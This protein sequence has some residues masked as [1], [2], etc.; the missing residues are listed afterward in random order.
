MS[1]TE[2]S[3]SA[4]SGGSYMMV[5]DNGNKNASGSQQA[6]SLDFSVKFV[7]TGAHYV[8]V[9]TIATNGSDDS[10]VPAY[11]NA[12]ITQMGV[13]QSAT[14]KWTKSSATFSAEI[15]IQSFKIFMREDGLK[16]D[17]IQLTDDANYTPSGGTPPPPPTAPDAPSGLAAS[18]TSS[19]QISLSWSDNASDE[20]GFRVER[21]TGGA[22]S[23]IAT[24][25]ANATS[26]SDT[27]LAAATAYS[28]RVRA[29]NSSGDSAYSG[30]AS[31]TTQA[32][33]GGGG[34]STYEAED[35]ASQSGTSL[36]SQGG[37]SGG[38]LVDYGG[39]GSYMQWDDISE[40]AGSATLTFTYYNGSSSNRQ[41]E[42]IV[43]G[44]NVGNVAFAP[45]GNW[46]TS[47]TAS[48]VATLA[49]GNNTVRVRANTGSGGPNLDYVE[50]SGGGAPPPTAPDAPSG[51]AASASSSSQIGLS[52]SDNASDET[53]FRVERSTGGAFSQVA[54]LGANATSYSDTGLAASTAYTYRV[55]AYNSS[56]DSAYSGTASATTQ[57][58][59]GGGGGS[60]DFYQ[61]ASSNGIVSM[62]AENA[63][64]SV[65]SSGGDTWQSASDGSASGATYMVVPDNTASQGSGLNGAG[66]RFEVDF[67][68]SG[69]HYV[70]IRFKADDAGD[71][72]CIIGL[73][74]VAK[75]NVYTGTASSWKWKKATLSGVS[76]GQRTFAL[77]MREDGF[78]LDK[79]VITSSSGYTPTGTGPAQTAN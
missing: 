46:N 59:S 12:N 62:E 13:T 35:Y 74:G 68:N 21:S 41:G 38:T 25:G 14:W 4:A 50:I 48:I 27:G 36:K 72:S 70:W 6:P 28:Y 61:D 32:A 11:N 71:D 17:Q 78:E 30:T 58:A 67:V 77:H 37:A 64:S 63:T 44:T 60:G 10:L 5:P 79:I 9:R 19:S 57:A 1:W 18:A 16:L 47:G 51:L 24:L 3:D 65:A 49:A 8:W 23:Q 40:G 45:T 42:V 69:T 26:Y 15:G 73:D 7:K 54:T 22:F 34:G 33:S 76:A 31:A 66:L 53:G 56:G 75:G 39:N 29:Y 20:T 43:N 2:F 55:L 52:W